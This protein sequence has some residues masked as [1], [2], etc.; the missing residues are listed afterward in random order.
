M[1]KENQKRIIEACPQMFNGDSFYFEC[2]DG[3]A[4]LLHSMAHFIAWKMKRWPEVVDIRDKMVERGEEIRP[5][6]VEY[7][8]QKP[9]DP[10]EHFRVDQ[11]KEKFG[12]L[13]FYVGGYP[14]TRDGWEV[15]GMITF[16][17]MISGRICEA[18][19]N[20]GETR[21]GGWVQTLCD[22]CHNRGKVV[23]DNDEEVKEG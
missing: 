18:C 12:T 5:W 13:R 14:D 6:I 1:N 11:I 3:W 7:F 2:G 9:T 22:T 19:G 16:A 10:W 21:P 4:D 20:P 8:E 23:N 15:T 17:E